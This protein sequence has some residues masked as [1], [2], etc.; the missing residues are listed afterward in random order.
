M[1]LDDSKWMYAEPLETVLQRL[2]TSEKGLSPEA[3]RERLR[4]RGPNALTR[5]PPKPLFKMIR[6]QLTDLMMVILGAAAVL[7]VFLNEWSEAA[8][9]LLIIV[10]NVVISVIQERKATAAIEA[11][12][13]L[14]S[15]QAHVF[16]GGESVM[17][18][19]EELVPGDVVALADGSMVPADL[20]LLTCADLRI[21]EAA[22]TGESV[23]VEKAAGAAVEPGAPL[24]D[25]FN[26]AFS[27]SIVMY[28]RGVGVV[29]ATGMETEVGRIAKMLEEE[30]PFDTNLKRKLNA[31]GKA[32]TAAGLAACVLIFGVGFLYGQPLVPLLMISI[33]LAISVIPEGLPAT[34]TVVMA[35][36]VRRMARKQALIRHLPAVETLGSATVICSDKTGTMTLNRMTVTEAEP[37]SDDLFRAC[38]LCNDAVMQGDDSMLGDPTETALLQFSR[39]RGIA[40]GALRGSLSRVAEMPFDSDRKRM[41]TLHRLPDGTL[42]SYTKGAADSILPRCATLLTPS[43]EVPMTGALRQTIQAKVEAMSAQALRVLGFARRAWSEAPARDRDLEENLCFLGVTGMIDP[44]REEVAAAVAA[45]RRAGIRTVMIT[46][47][48]KITAAAIAT[49]LGVMREGYCVMTG[50]ELA[51]LDDDALTAAIDRVAVFARVSPSDKLRIIRALRAN[52]EIAAMTGDGVNDAPALKAADIGV[53]MGITGTDVAKEA[54]DMVLLDDRFTTIVSAVREGRRIYRNIQKVIR[55]LLAGNSAEVMTLTLA[56]LFNWGSPYLAVHIL[57]VNLATASLPALALGVDPA[58]RTGM[59][60]PPVRSGSLFDAHMIR[61]I[62][63][64]GCVVTAVTLAAYFIGVHQGGHKLGQTLGF[65]TLAFTQIFRG[66]TLR[67]KTDS[68][69]A[70]GN[71]HNPWLY[72]ATAASAAM[73]AL[74]FIVPAF[75]EAFRLAIPTLRQWMVVAAFVGVTLAEDEIDKAVARL[76]N[77]KKAALQ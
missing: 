47:D 25:R 54:A 38:A 52:G 1:P 68:L 64:Q 17:I 44:P 40:I 12:R 46:G 22:L 74:L 3:A 9:I 45:C 72:A 5:K 70:K 61:R 13:K 10:V 29:A 59:D 50:P 15:P 4:T 55:F 65:S 51:D 2:E 7:S 32:I 31:A 26:M 69:F 49:R 66:V 6:E 14:S 30:E 20:R 48:H 24:G 76:R 42:L 75:R 62:V 43:G 37:L 33:S 35:L 27:S 36:G 67:S 8:V 19:S 16:R 63:V 60:V 58:E 28:G 56:T 77:R 23:P 34:A 53:A 57:W 73:M 39:E 21:Q 41:T 18:P 71:G 11:L